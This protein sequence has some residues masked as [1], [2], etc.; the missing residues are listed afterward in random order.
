MHSKRSLRGWQ[1]EVYI[2]LHNGEDQIEYRINAFLEV[3]AI[4]YDKTNA[5]GHP[6]AFV[7][8]PE[9]DDEEHRIPDHLKDRHYI[10]T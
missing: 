8:V 1:Y 6:I 7:D 5:Y 10:C 9:I 3:V 4:L 2:H